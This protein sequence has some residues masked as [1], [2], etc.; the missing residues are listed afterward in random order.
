MKI[1][2]HDAGQMTKMATMPIYGINTLKILFPGFD[3][4]G[5]EASEIEANY[6]LF[7]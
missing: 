6:C 3:E 1:N 7:K 5:H 2:K 4:T